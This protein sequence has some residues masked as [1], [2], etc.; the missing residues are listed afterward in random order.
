M[1]FRHFDSQTTGGR[2]A[3]EIDCER[4]AGPTIGGTSRAHYG[5]PAFSAIVEIVQLQRRTV[6]PT[7]LI[8]LEDTESDTPPRRILPPSSSGIEDAVPGRPCGAMTR[9]FP[10]SRVILALHPLDGV[11]L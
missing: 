4:A 3:V 7:A 9:A 1:G 10:R 2:T 6:Q 5:F 11:H 8:T